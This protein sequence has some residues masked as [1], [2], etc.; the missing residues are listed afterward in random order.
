MMSEATPAA[1]AAKR[2][3]LVDDDFEIIES[4]ANVA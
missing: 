3:L 1:T 2:I 4:L